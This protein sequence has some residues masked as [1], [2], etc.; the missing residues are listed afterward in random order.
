MFRSRLMIGFLVVFVLL[1]SV[2]AAFAQTPVPLTTDDIMTGAQS[3]I[4]DYGLM[5]LVSIAAF[6]GVA[7]LLVRRMRRAAG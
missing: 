7:A 5:A 1:A 4:G 6:V 2:T 3:L